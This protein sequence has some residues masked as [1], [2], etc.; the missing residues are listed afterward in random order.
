MIT[1]YKLYFLILFF[2]LSSEITAQLSPG[3]LSNAH[4]GLEGT[5]NCT[6]CHDLGKKVSNTKCLDCHIELKERVSQ[7]KGFHFS[8]EVRNKDCFECHSEHHGRDFEMIRFDE[9]NFDHTKTGYDLTGAHQIIDCRECHNA[10]FIQDDRV[11]KLNNSFL[12]LSTNCVDCH[13]DVHQNTLGNDCASC[14]D[15]KVFSPAEYFNHD[16]ADFRLFG[17]HKVL[18]CI[19]CHKE[20][21]RNGKPFQNFSNIPF[22]DCISCHED[23]HANQLKGT[24]KS[25]HN[26]LSFENTSTLGKYNHNLTN[27]PLTGA[28][29]KI[30]CN[31]C[32]QLDVSPTELFQSELGI[33]LEDCVHCHQDVHEGKFGVNCIDCH[34]VNSFKGNFDP[35]S[36]NHGL[37]DFPLEGKH[38][39]V[40]CIECHGDNTL[41]RIEHDQCIDCHED[42]HEGIFSTRD[43]K[44]CHLTDGFEI[45]NYS[46]EQHN[47]SSNFPLTGSHIATPCLLC[48]QDL[49]N[50]KEEI[51]KFRSIG[52]DCIDCHENIH[53]S[54]IDP[55]IYPN[56]DCTVC[57]IT[58]SWSESIFDHQVTSF[59]L[60]GKHASI[61]CRDC[62]WDN[63]QQKRVFEQVGSECIDCHIDIHFGQFPD[64]NCTS[65]HSFDNWIASKFSHDRAK[66]KLDGSHINVKC[67]KCHLPETS[68]GNT[69]ILYKTNRIQCIDCH[70]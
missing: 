29:A 31:S 20:E 16:E 61:N 68:N 38:L 21:T 12:G 67:E 49:S 50:T 1:R 46:I 44:E 24:C 17:K 18:E 65:C 30:N 64:Q 47:E 32:H 48:H 10:D 40:S 7:K 42:F 39:D 53:T 52:A 35:Q 57:H 28:H 2:G 5:I 14:H 41:E 66:F 23:V 6:E 13:E 8:L 58:D 25:C 69:Y 22:S 60:Q 54:E 43:C 62:H 26:E 59:E 11:K 63:D 37:T 51:W 15:T 55:T 34:N 4:S 27:F 19:E 56:N 3:K 70:Y 9:K 36:F 33:F 45:I